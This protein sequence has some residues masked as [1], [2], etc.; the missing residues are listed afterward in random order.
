MVTPFFQILEKIQEKIQLITLLKILDFWEAF[1]NLS[2]R[3]VYNYSSRNSVL[4]G[5]VTVFAVALSSFTL[6]FAVTPISTPG[7]LYQFGIYPESNQCSKNYLKCAYG[8]PHTT[9][10]EPGLA[11]DDKTHSCN[12]PDLLDFCSPEGNSHM[13]KCKHLTYSELCL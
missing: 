8:V 12:W 1:S 3:R 7:C 13:L 2:Y 6:P 11:Y 5:R 9:P 4:P 10:C